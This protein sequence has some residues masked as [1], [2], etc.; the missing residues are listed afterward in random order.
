MIVGS[1]A[2]VVQVFQV[3]HQVVDLRRIQKLSMKTF[4]SNDEGLNMPSS[5]RYKS[6][7]KISL[8][9]WSGHLHG[10]HMDN[11]LQNTIEQV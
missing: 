9:N 2:L 1:N 8:I 3:G 10:I 5:C 6:V 7:F 11:I 4:A